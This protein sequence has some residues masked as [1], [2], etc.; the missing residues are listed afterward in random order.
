MS[1]KR[2]ALYYYLRSKNI[3]SAEIA[4][5]NN[6]SR[7]S[8]QQTLGQDYW[9]LRL[10]VFKRVSNALGIKISD[11]IDE[12]LRINDLVEKNKDLDET[13]FIENLRWGIYD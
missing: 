9:K 2:N 10:I 4:R 5:K 3:N 8:F 13:E 7:Q 12:T 11:L 6:I 1:L